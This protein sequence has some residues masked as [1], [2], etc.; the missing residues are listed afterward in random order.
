M[1]MQ[2]MELPSHEFISQ[3]VRDDPAEYEKLRRELLESLIDSAPGHLK[4]RLRGMKFRLDSLHQRAGPALGTAVRAYE[5]MWQSFQAMNEDLQDFLRI[6]SQLNRSHGNASTGA[7]A[8]LKPSARILEFRARLR[9]G[10][11]TV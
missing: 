5:M 3:L 11:E 6:A 8:N 9:S 2:P 1:A 4:P 7:E 10:R